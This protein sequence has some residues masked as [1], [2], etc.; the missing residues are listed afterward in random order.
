MDRSYIT[1]H[2]KEA[3]VN[4]FVTSELKAKHFEHRDELLL[5]SRLYNSIYEQHIRDRILNRGPNTYKGHLGVDGE[6][7]SI[8]KIIK[9]TLF[10]VGKLL[11]L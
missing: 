2:H 5:Y 6:R 10:T 3:G 4:D 8:I 7:M 9:N 1:S 11:S